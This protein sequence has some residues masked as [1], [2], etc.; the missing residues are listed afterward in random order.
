MAY[1]YFSSFIYYQFYCCKLTI[2]IRNKIERPRSEQ[3][4]IIQLFRDY[5]K[6]IG[7]H[8]KG[9]LNRSNNNSVAFKLCNTK[10]KDTFIPTDLNNQIN[11]KKLYHKILKECKIFAMRRIHI[12]L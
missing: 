1:F 8:M 4:K 6:V 2:T 3:L 10:K 7:Q 12:I 5:K 9:K 11:Q